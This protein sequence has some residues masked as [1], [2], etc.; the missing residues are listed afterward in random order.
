[1]SPRP[2]SVAIVAV[3][4]LFAA[5]HCASSIF[6]TNYSYID[7]K[8][9]TAGT[10]AMPYQG[11]IGM[12]PLLQAAER[13]P[14]FV[15]LAQKIDAN[16]HLRHKRYTFETITAQKLASFLAG[17]VALILTVAVALF[18]G[19]RR[20]PTFWWLPPTLLLVMLYITQ[21]ARYEV[22]LWYPWDLPHALLFGSACLLILEGAWIPVMLLFLVD[23][24][25]RETAIF[26]VPLTLCVAWVRNQRKQGLVLAVLMLAAW[27]P[28]RSYILHRFAA[29]PATEMGLHIGENF[30]NVVNP[31]HWPQMLSAFGFLLLP[32]ILGNRLLTPSQRAFLLGA[33]PC[34][35]VTL[36]YGMWYETRIFGEWLLP[37]AVLLTAEADRLFIARSSAP[38]V[39]IA[40]T[41]A[42]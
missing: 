5:I 31:S 19:L 10:A 20:F 28:F 32:L 18:Y 11:R 39:E 33:L 35:I 34:L 27:I 2:A 4:L 14:G 38:E 40:R 7:L 37:G 15:A 9:Y 26:L 30:H 36:G 17:T 25:I 21:A 24:P 41:Y 8:L 13:S 12:M 42:A 1:M 29:N 16:R 3:L 22:T 6:W 23:L